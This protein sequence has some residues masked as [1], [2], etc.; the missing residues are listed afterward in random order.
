MSYPVYIGIAGWSYPDWEGIVYT[1]TRMDQLAYVSGFVDCLE[2][3]STFY[4]PPSER[5]CTS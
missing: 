3:N 2:I 4:R 5:N 1:S